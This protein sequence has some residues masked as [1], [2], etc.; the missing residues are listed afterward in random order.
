MPE[1]SPSTNVTYIQDDSD[2]EMPDGFEFTEEQIAS[3]VRGKFYED[4]VLHNGT[5]AKRADP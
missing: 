4:A 2:Y 3:A 5:T 1:K